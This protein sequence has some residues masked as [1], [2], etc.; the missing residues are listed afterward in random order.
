MSRYRRRAAT[1]APLHPTVPEAVL[2]IV[3]VLAS[4]WLAPRGMETSAILQLL[5]GTGLTGTAVVAGVRWAR[6]SPLA[7]PAV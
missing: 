3:I 1:P 6:R 7:L 5:G 2:V 4:A